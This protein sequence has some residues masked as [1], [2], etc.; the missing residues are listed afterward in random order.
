MITITRPR[1]A[2]AFSA[3]CNSAQS[4]QLGTEHL[5]GIGPGRRSLLRAVFGKGLLML[6]YNALPYGMG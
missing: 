4:L 2:R 3:A 1:P 6:F 5:A